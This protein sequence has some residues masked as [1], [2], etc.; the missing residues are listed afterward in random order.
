MVRLD[1]LRICSVLI[2]H[3]FISNSKC[4][5]LC[6]VWRAGHRV[7]PESTSDET[8]VQDTPCGD[9]T[10]MQLVSEFTTLHVALKVSLHPCSHTG[11]QHLTPVMI[12]K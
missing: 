1:L 9:S 6:Y 4:P 12:D 3:Q 5:P 11:P 8:V 7:P 2:V 10:L